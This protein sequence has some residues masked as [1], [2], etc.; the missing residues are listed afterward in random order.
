MIFHFANSLYRNYTGS[1]WT[2]NDKS[3]LF[4]F[5]NPP[6]EVWEPETQSQII[7]K[8]DGENDIGISVS[9]DLYTASSNMYLWVN[10]HVFIVLHS[11]HL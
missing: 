3:E 7:R 11:I 2:D 5:A 9:K 1:S 4:V 8:Y 10:T 6:I